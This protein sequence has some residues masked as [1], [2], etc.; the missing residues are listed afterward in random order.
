MSLEKNCNPKL[1]KDAIAGV[2]NEQHQQHLERHIESCPSCQSQMESFAGDQIDWQKASD[3]LNQSEVSTDPYLGE[4]TVDIQLVRG[5]SDY[6][7]E[8]IEN[9]SLTHSPQSKMLQP[10][11]H[12]EML[13]R[14]DG[15]EIE[16]MIGRG[17]MGIVYKG[18][19]SELNR[20][21]AIKVLANHLAE[22]G[23]ARQRFAREARAAAAVIHPNVVPIHSVNSSAECPYIV[24]TLVSGRSL[25]SHV[26]QNGA[27][28]VKEIVRIGKQIA[29]GLSAAHREGLVHRDIKPANILLEK[30]VS[31][32]MIT[33]FGLARAADDAAITQTGWLAGTPHYMSPEQVT[34]KEVDQRSDLFSLGS[35]LYFMATGRE[36][37]RADMTVAIL[38]KIA[39]QEPNS[40]YSINSDMTPT[41]SHIIEKLLSKNPEHRFHTAEEVEA[42]LTQYLAHLEQPNIQPKPKI[43]L[44]RKT[45]WKNSYVLQT[46]GAVT[47]II[48]TA[49]TTT[50]WNTTPEPNL[51]WP[52][53]LQTQQRWNE[54]V[55]Q[56]SQDL[57]SLENRSSSL[58]Q[59]SEPN[60]L[61][62]FEGELQAL[63][64]QINQI[65]QQLNTKPS[66]RN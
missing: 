34:G 32:V 45:N 3:Y 63:A 35:V 59:Y 28:N 48:A 54:E 42:I 57:E 40:V 4:P 46:M 26:A 66:P 15:F 1:L 18:F 17:G 16:Q 30:D 38:Q 31:R 27:F 19:D 49:L 2:L 43:K 51:T 62:V 7:Y 58:N 55:D 36:P 52:E 21:V 44:V 5:E 65:E 11:S 64:R 9:E 56:L 24:M 12:P 29:A 25:Q 61:D 53:G 39:E 47:L 33:D 6:R 8:L 14:I 13:G 22:S 20:P 41:I 60:A 50:Y 10:A 37:F 23:V